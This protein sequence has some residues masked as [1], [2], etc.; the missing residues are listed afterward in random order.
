MKIKKILVCKV[1]FRTDDYPLMDFYNQFF[2]LE[3]I[4]EMFLMKY[5]ENI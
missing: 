5:F 1:D 2:E 3:G 4:F